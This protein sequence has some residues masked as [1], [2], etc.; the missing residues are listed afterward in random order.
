MKQLFNWLRKEIKANSVE[1]YTLELVAKDRVCSLV[2]AAEAKWEE[3]CC[4]WKKNI[5]FFR[6]T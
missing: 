2:D 3:D 4:V 1:F 5:Y 6:W